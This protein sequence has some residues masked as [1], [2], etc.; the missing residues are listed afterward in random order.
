M[1]FKGT[2][3]SLDTG[4]RWNHTADELVTGFG[5]GAFPE[6]LSE[7]E[8]YLFQYITRRFVKAGLVHKQVTNKR[9]TVTDG[10]PGY[11]YTQ[12]IEI[13]DGEE[14]V[15]VPV[16]EPGVMS[17]AN[18]YKY[19]T[20]CVC[21][22]VL[23][24]V[25][26]NALYGYGLT[27]QQASQMRPI[28]ASPFNDLQDT[29]GGQLNAL[30]QHFPFLRWYVLNDGNYFFYHDRETDEDL[31]TDPFVKEQ[32]E[33]AVVLPAVYDVTPAGT[34]TIRCPFITWVNPTMTV[35]F[36]SRF[37]K[38]TFTS[39]FYPVKTKA[40]L[41][42]TSSVEFATV[43]DINNVEM[44]CVDIPEKDAPVIDYATGEIKPKPAEQPNETP[45][46]AKIQERRS[47]QWTEKTLEVVPRKTGADNTDSRWAGIVEKELRPYFRPE[48]WPEGKLFTETLALNALKEWN[49]DYFDPG[50]EYMK[51][52]DAVH[53][54]SLEN[55][56][57]GIGGRTGIEVPWLKVGDKI[58]V[59]YP[60]QSEYPDDEKVDM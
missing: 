50:G 17:V 41:V 45:E 59:R 42:I 23:K 55:D 56:I 11:T 52:S 13:N 19:G 33:R 39:Y 6:G 8:S 44:T 49:E 14:W 58:V 2:V 40:Y 26:A 28:P 51:R 38:G 24:G 16:D 47:L 46:S 9:K 32:Q 3:G 35:L 48:N 43:E 29:V 21:S 10:E 34:R 27:A 57:T 54:R 25:E 5:D 30:Q 15:E 31:W 20:S 12:N 36:S 60:F 37:N 18:A 1:Y 53:G 22:K 4:L 7:I